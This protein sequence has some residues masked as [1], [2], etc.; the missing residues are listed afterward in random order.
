MNE[1]LLS[2]IVILNIENFAVH[3]LI[4]NNLIRSVC[5]VEP[6]INRTR[7]FDQLIIKNYFLLPAIWA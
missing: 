3:I 5:V 4:L 1:Q 6:N 7:E 2:L